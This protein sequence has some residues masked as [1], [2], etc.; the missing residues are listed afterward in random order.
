MDAVTTPPAPTNEPTLSYAPGSAERKSLE[1]ELVRLQESPLELTAT[2]GGEQVAG[3]GAEIDVVQPHAH[4]TVLGT[5]RNST[6]ADAQRAVDAATE[7]APHLAGAAL[8][9]A[10]RD[11]PQGGRPAQ[12]PVARD[13]ERRHHAGSVQDG[14]AGRDRRGL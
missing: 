14:L 3:G 1:A 7:A 10:R 8:R 2:I 5:M 4:A 6:R 9:R 13:A 12:R 11:H